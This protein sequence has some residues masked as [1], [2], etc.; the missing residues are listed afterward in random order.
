MQIDNLTLRRLLTVKQFFEHGKNHRESSTS[1]GRM[2][3]CHHFDWAV[4]MLLK[5][6]A[7][8]LEL[9]INSKGIGFWTLWDKLE[10][11]YQRKYGENIPL[12]EQIRTLRSTRN[13]VQ[14]RAT[15]PSK[16][17]LEKLEIYTR[18]FMQR[19]IEVVF[20]KNIEDIRLSDLI[21]INTLKKLIDN[22]KDK[23]EEGEHI[24]SI[25]YSS[26]AFEYSKEFLLKQSHM[27]LGNL[28]STNIEVPDPNGEGKNQNL[29]DAIDDLVNAYED[30]QTYLEKMRDE[31]SLFLFD[32][33][34]R[35][36]LKFKKISFP[37]DAYWEEGRLITT[38]RITYSFSFKEGSIGDLEEPSKSKEEAQFCYD[39]VLDFI[40][41]NGL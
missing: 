13:E 6:V 23:L 9:D 35:K 18:D 8:H 20:D 4:E 25:A 16:E 15:V 32:I 14:H 34:G 41:D 24:S 3:A 29:I 1:F 31:Y 22:A 38:P 26:R 30:L 10:K 36:F 33:D 12:K 21:T 11:H 2:V 17:E 7:S 37:I 19:T 5:T 40:L 28:P 39:F 27:S